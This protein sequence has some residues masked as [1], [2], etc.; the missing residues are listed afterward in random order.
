MVINENDAKIVYKDV[1]LVTKSQWSTILQNKDITRDLDLKTVLSVYNSPQHRSTA[2]E[3]AAMLGKENYHII[4]GGNT[5]FSKRICNYLNIKPPKN[6]KGGNRW[7]TIPYLGASKGDGKWYYVIRPELKEA[8]E[9]LLDTGKINPLDT[10]LVTN[11]KR[12]FKTPAEILE[13]DIENLFEG[14][15]KSIIVNAYER[16]SKAR[17]LCLKEHGHKCCVCGFDFAE[18][19]GE[20]GAGYIEVHHLK[21]LNEINEKYQVDPV[22][23]LIP[24]C[25]NCH[26]MLHKANI[27]IEELKLLI[28]KSPDIV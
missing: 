11:D 6:S 25:P 23:D 20:I 13:K 12:E 22:N 2:T 16:S 9:E 19:Y 7:W 1:P 24:V 21:P 8:I 14:A 15:K 27:S 4:A 3:I 5:S 17:H 10:P 26:A 28:R 18:F